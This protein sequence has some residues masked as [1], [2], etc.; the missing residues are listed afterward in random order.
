MLEKKIL[1]TISCITYNH[2]NYITQAIESFLMQETNFDYEILIHDDAS[3]DGTSDI[4]RRY[5]KAFPDVIKPIIQLNNQV[6]LGRSRIDYHY[7]HSRSKGKY[8]ALCEGDDY[9]VDK[10]KL[11]KQIDYLENNPSC[12][13]CFH[14]A[15]IQCSNTMHSDD[16][17]VP[18]LHENQQQ[19][20][21]DSRHYSSGK[22]QLL[23]YIPTASFVYPK[24]VLD[25]PPQWFFDAPVGDNAVKLIASSYGYAHY[26]NEP[27]SVYRFGVPNSTTSRWKDDNLSKRIERYDAFI[28]MLDQFNTFSSFRYDE[29]IQ[30]SKLT[31]EY[32][33]YRDIGNRNALKDKKFQE[34]IDSMSIQD[35]IKYRVWLHLPSVYNVFRKSRK[36]IG[37][38]FNK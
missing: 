10:R 11:Q 38:R 28:N 21:N 16:L 12:T 17:V 19:F 14:N 13:F 24:Y 9:W 22:L 26:F 15:Y 34:H 23:G 25:D 20:S 7:N 8:I 30:H 37:L 27:M 3:T 6:S 4:I 33:K 18:W 36:I 35:R 2:E 29:D 5:Q 31:W 32:L 1:V